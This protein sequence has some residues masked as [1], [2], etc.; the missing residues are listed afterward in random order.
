MVA[1][2]PKVL[3]ELP[4]PR[5]GSPF[6]RSYFSYKYNWLLAGAETNPAVAPWA[7]HAYTLPG[8]TLIVGTTY[9][10]VPASTETA[11]FID[12]PQLVCF[13]TDDQPGTDR[14]MSGAVF[15]QQGT[16]QIT[17]PATGQKHQ[18]IRQVAPVH[19]MIKGAPGAVAQ[20]LTDNSPTLMGQINVCYCDGSVRTVTVSQGQVD[21]VADPK[22]QLV[23]DDS[24]N[25]GARRAGS[26][27]YIEGTRFDPTFPP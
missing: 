19:G 4:L 5:T 14:G 6:V 26:H 27:S 13:Q 2:C 16:G 8:T 9:K 17:I 12:F 1:V 25:G 18:V 23:L 3:S 22:A 21:N 24:T 7:P 11:M 20:F 10:K 15:N